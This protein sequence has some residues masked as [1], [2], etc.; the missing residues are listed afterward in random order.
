MAVE[1]ECKFLEVSAKTG[2]NI[3]ELFGEVVSDIAC[4]TR[5]RQAN[6]LLENGLTIQTKGSSGNKRSKCC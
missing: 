4:N 5:A 6:N 1:N 2:Y 3:K